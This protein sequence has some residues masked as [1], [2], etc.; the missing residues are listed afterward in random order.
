MNKEKLFWQRFC[1]LTD[2]RLRSRTGLTLLGYFDDVPNLMP[3][4]S[5]TESVAEHIFGVM[6]LAYLFQAIY[7]VGPTSG[8]N[9]KQIYELALLHEVGER[10]IGDL[11]DDGSRDTLEKDRREL[12]LMIEF[13]DGFSADAVRETCINFKR[14]QK[15]DSFTYLLDKFHFVLMQLWLMSGGVRGS[16]NDKREKGLLSAQDEEFMKLTMSDEAPVNTAA[17]FLT[18][19]KGIGGREYCIKILE[20]V[21]EMIYGEAPSSLKQFY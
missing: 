20:E 1:W 15:C 21:F 4:E 17:S 9:A 16:M 11:P 19:T 2:L 8:I 6:S 5:R 18:R 12:E 3:I 14:F 13:T 7:G 10:E